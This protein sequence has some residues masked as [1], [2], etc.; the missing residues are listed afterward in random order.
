MARF[1]TDSDAT[2]LGENASLPAGEASALGLAALSQPFTTITGPTLDVTATTNYA[3]DTMVGVSAITFETTA[4]SVATFS[5]TQFGSAAIALN[6]TITGDSHTDTMDVHVGAGKAFNGSLLAFDNWSA[7]DKFE[8]TLAGDNVNIAGTS[9]ND[10]IDAGAHFDSTDVINGGGGNSTLELDGDYANYVTVTSAMLQNVDK[11][12]LAAGHEY[13]LDIDSG[14]VA[15]GKTMTIDAASETASD[16]ANL[17]LY[18]DT[19]GSY[20]LDLGNGDNY[21]FLS[22]AQADTLHCTGGT[23]EVDIYGTMAAGDKIE[24]AGNTIVSLFGDYSA[25]YTFGAKEFSGLDAIYLNG[26]DTYNLT[27]NNANV[28]SGGYLVVNGEAIGAGYNFTLN[29]SHLVGGNLDLFG[30]AGMNTL[31][32]GGGNDGFSFDGTNMFTAADRI[33]G[34]GGTENTVTLSG[35][36]SAGLVFQNATI[37][38]IQ[39]LYLDAGNSYNLTLAA[40]NATAGHSLEVYAGQLAATNTVTING[41]HVAGN[42]TL[43]G[44]A[45]NDILKGGS[46]TNTFEGGAGADV[47]TAGSGANTFLYYSAAQSTSTTHDTIVDF[48][49]LNDIIDLD[50]GFGAPG[51]VNPAVTSG[52][53]STTHFD[54]NLAA[55]IGAGQLLAHDAVLFTPSAGNLAGH[56]F[57]IVDENGTAGYQAG[58]DLVVELTNATNMSHF[59]TSDFT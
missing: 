16:V 52:T 1:L 57:L 18:N 11:I 8:V 4:N 7:T 10:T 33:N 46:G 55:A 34:E 36:Y 25:G 54:A 5:S 12:D 43:D 26:N 27:L 9:A 58:A 41:S 56:T 48:N 3:P 24:G 19:I 15:A 22:G 31:T 29:G 49:A 14:V 42:L 45:G 53:L 2:Y 51:A 37:Q 32:G 30:C 47:M 38:N 13:S 20:I 59:G 39:Q 50:F 44:G 23:N 21:I 28:A 35:D 17:D 40:G 6:T